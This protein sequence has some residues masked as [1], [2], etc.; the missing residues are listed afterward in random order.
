[1]GRVGELKGKKE[2]GKGRQ[3]STWACELLLMPLM[4]YSWLF[5]VY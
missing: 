1:M 4:Y 2:H 3:G 5:D